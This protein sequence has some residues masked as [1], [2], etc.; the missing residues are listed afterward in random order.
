MIKKRVR[1]FIKKKPGERFHYLHRLFNKIERKLSHTL[2]RHIIGLMLIIA[3]ILMLVL[4]GPGILTILTGLA[5][6]GL[7]S[8][9]FA[10]FLDRLELKLRKPKQDSKK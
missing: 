2:L 8:R 6:I 4:P 3:G 9:T 5:L 7:G 1:K 10:V